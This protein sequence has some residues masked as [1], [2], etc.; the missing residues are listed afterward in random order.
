[1]RARAILVI[2]RR[3]IVKCLL[4]ASAFGWAALASLQKGEHAAHADDLFAAQWLTMVLAMTPPL[5]I[6]EIE[7]LWRSSLRRRRQLTVASFVIAYVAVWL[8]AGEALSMLLGLMTITTNHILF[9]AVLAALWHGSPMRQRRLNAC[10]RLP[11][12]RVFG[13]VAQWDSIRYG[14]RAAGNCVAACFPV[15]LLAFMVAK[16][17]VTIMAIAAVVMTVERY[18]PARQPRW[19]FATTQQW[20]SV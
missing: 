8:L 4:I 2:A 10:H 15:M 17:H 13:T 9:A 12:L 6:R 3:P 7:C 14:V 11:T 16:H 18:L 20:S 1:M 5:L 19:R